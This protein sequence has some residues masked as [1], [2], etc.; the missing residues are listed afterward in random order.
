LRVII[1]CRSPPEFDQGPFKT[2]EE[3]YE[4]TAEPELQIVNGEQRRDAEDK[5]ELK[6]VKP[7]KKY[8]LFKY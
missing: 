6:L 2:P 4:Q 1:L 3:L 8:S 5:P 7:V